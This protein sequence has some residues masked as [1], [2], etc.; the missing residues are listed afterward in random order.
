M[1]GSDYQAVI[2]EGIRKYD[3][4]RPYQNE[5]KLLWDPIDMIDDEL[6]KYISSIKAAAESGTTKIP[7]GSHIR[8]D[9][10]VTHI[11]KQCP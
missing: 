1:V 3:D 9:E 5:D 4:A 6:T 11:Q 2:P 8:D 7:Q 10:Q